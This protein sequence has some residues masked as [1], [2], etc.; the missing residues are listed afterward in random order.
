MLRAEAHSGIRLQEQLMIHLGCQSDCS[1]DVADRERVD[2]LHYGVDSG[3]GVSQA[4]NGNRCKPHRFGVSR[5]RTSIWRTNL[6]G[7][8]TGASAMLGG[9]ASC[10]F[11]KTD[12]RWTMRCW[13]SDS[14]TSENRNFHL[15]F[16]RERQVTLGMVTQILIKLLL[17]YFF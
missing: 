11:H 7:M 8:Q 17:F 15:L 16:P 1:F 2:D 12:I 9:R 3:F 4:C 6:P 5:W 14:S 13:R 10:R